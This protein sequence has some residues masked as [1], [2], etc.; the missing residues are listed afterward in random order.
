M[1]L[2]LMAEGSAA[3]APTRIMPRSAPSVEAARRAD[4][5][6]R[7]LMD[8]TR[9]GNGKMQLEPQEFGAAEALAEAA[10]FAAAEAQRKGITISVIPLEWP[11]TAHA[12]RH[13]VLQALDNLISNAV[14]FTEVGSVLLTTSAV[15]PSGPGRARKPAG[16]SIAMA[17]HAGGSGG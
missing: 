14:K 7:D 12:D 6:I 10:D 1:A 4:R 5:L 8:I 17:S 15:T 2:L 11:L 13:R 9:I 3:V 16:Q